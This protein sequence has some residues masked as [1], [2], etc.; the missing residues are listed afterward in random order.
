MDANAYRFLSRWQ[1][2]ADR[3][4]IYGVLADLGSYPQWWPQV[5]RVEQYDADTALVVVRS[6]L[7]YAL[8]VLTTSVRDDPV[9]GVLEARLSG[10]VEGW[11]RWTLPAIDSS[12]PLVYEQVVVARRA[13]LRRLGPVAR[14]FFRAN[15]AV[16]MRAGQR[17]LRARVT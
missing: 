8:R 12:G 14:P 1:V 13:L 17:G 5:R 2:P 11:S 7:P 10:D 9:E 6:F 15:H 3:G 16:M 4:T